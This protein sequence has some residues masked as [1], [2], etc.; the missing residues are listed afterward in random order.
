MVD[1]SGLGLWLYENDVIFQPKC[2]KVYVVALLVIF[3][4][5]VAKYYEDIMLRQNFRFLLILLSLGAAFCFYSDVVAKSDKIIAVVN[6]DVITQS[7]LD[8]KVAAMQQH[9]ARRFNW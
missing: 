5:M 4:I 7:E 1:S 2:E 9:A 3:T 6:D 8:A